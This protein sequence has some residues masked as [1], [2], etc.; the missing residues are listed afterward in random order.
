MNK[1]CRFARIL[2]RCFGRYDDAGNGQAAVQAWLAKLEKCATACR[3]YADNA[4]SHLW[5]TKL[6][7][8]KKT[9]SFRRIPSVGPAAGRMAVG[10]FTVS[11]GQSLRSTSFNGGRIQ[12]SFETCVQCPAMRAGRWKN[13]IPPAGGFPR[14]R[15]PT[16]LIGGSKVRGG[17]ARS[18]LCG[19]HA[20][21]I[22]RQAIGRQAYAAMRSSQ[23]FWK[24]GVRRLHSCMQ[25]SC[26]M[27][28]LAVSV[29]TDSRTKNNGQ[30]LHRRQTLYS[31]TPDAIYDGI[32]RDAMKTRWRPSIWGD[33]IG[34]RTRILATRNEDA[35]RRAP[36]T[37]FGNALV[38]GRASVTGAE[39]IDQRVMV[40]G[41]GI[42]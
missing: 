6:S 24:L 2:M 8:R 37:K 41:P 7:K 36:L 4:G 18:A 30:K 3:Y 5:R 11:A 29:G 21:R 12:V 32:F 13:F 38:S 28:R 9:M 27:N 14:R 35:G 16:L 26:I 33:P 34:K 19:R 23:L 22:K 15:V 10:K 42:I 40:Q 1:S 39:A 20:N 31:S 17:S 25:S